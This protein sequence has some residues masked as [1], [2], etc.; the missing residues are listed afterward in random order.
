MRRFCLAILLVSLT[1][2]AAPR[3]ANTRADV[4]PQPVDYEATIREHL[5]RTLYDPYSVQDLRI[6]EPGISS[7][8]IRPGYAF[9]GWL[10]PVQMNAKNRYGAYVG[11][12]HSFYWFRG[13][14]LVL[15]T[16][17]RLQCP[18]GL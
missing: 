9:Y 10:V 6:D 17:D 11:L 18:E 1:A 8:T 4:G 3:F 7:C 2:C 14:Q 5:R 15:I 16:A 13:E 12:R